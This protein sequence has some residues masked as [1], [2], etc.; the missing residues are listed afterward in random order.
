M[1]NLGAEKDERSTDS[2]VE[3]QTWEEGRMSALQIQAMIDCQ[4]LAEMAM[5]GHQGWIKEVDGRLSDTG[6]E[7]QAWDMGRMSA[8]QIQG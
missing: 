6:A 5:L 4:A 8:F 7:Y 3:C 1:S 2:G